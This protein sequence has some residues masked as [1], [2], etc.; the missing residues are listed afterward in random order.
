MNIIPKNE[1]YFRYLFELQNS[2][3]TNMF[4]AGVYLM[5]K[6]GIDRNESKSVLSFWM[7]NYE[8]IAKELNIDI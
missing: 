1:K 6:F 8:E 3:S 2:G 4:G 7:V 5:E